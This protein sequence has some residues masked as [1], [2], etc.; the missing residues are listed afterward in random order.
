MTVLG[1][2]L[3]KAFNEKKNDINSYIWKGPRVNGVQAEYKLVDADYD[4]LKTW[5][6]KCQQML[7][8][9]DVHTPGRKTLINIIND[10]ILRCRAELLL[11]WLRKEK[12]YTNIKCLEDLRTIISNNKDVL[13]PE[14]IKTYPIKEVMDGLPLEYQ[15]V[16][17]K[18]VL[19]SCLDLGGVLDT[20]HIT[21]NFIIK[22]GLWFTPQELQNDLYQKDPDTG[23]PKNRLELVRDSLKVDPSIK[24]RISETG[25]T[26]S[27]FK[28]IYMLQKNKYSSYT[29]EQLTV[30]ASKILY[31][32]QLQCE[33]QAKQWEDKSAEI[34]KVANIKGWD[35]TR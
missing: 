28:A 30:L 17:I 11:R 7:Y 20:S 29:S 24:L 12:Q 13:T 34:A 2:E 3:T 23:K 14:A 4:T 18:Y 22:L 10:Q 9:K 1:D 27:E 6:N 31:R 26:Y 5:Y 25:L 35:V 15:D 19:D 16:P 8:N 32:L 21:R 33:D